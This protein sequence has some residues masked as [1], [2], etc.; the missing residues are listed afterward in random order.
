MHRFYVAQEIGG[1][2]I[3][4]TDAGQIHHLKD[5]LR[6]KVK[7]EVVIFNDLGREYTCF[8][9]E[10]GKK[11]AV[12]TVKDVRSAGDKKQKSRWPA[13]YPKRLRWMRL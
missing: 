3:F 1:D 6:L 9:A 11:Q 7:D 8:I 2:K 12:L 10:L 13:P 4:I 5:V